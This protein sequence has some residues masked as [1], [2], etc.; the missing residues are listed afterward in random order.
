MT[1]A[2]NLSLLSTVEVGATTDQ[3]KSDIDALGI[4]RGR[5]NLII[6]GGFDVSQRGTSFTADNSYTLDR[7]KSSDG[8]GSPTPARTVTQQAFT[9]GQTDVPNA[10]YYLRHVQTTATPNANAGL[11]QKVEDVTQTSGQTFTFSFYAKASAA[12]SV[13]LNF[14]QHFGSGGSPSSSVTTTGATQT[15]STSWVKYVITKTLPSISGKTLG[16]NGDDQLTMDFTYLTS[17]TFTFEIANVQL[18][19]GSVATDFEHRSYG[20][21]LALCQRYFC[22]NFPTGTTPDHGLNINQHGVAGWTCFSNGAAARSNFIY[23]PVTMRTTPSLVLYS[24][25]SSDA[26]GVWAAYVGSWDSS[27]TNSS[28]GTNKNFNVRISAGITLVAGESYLM[29][30]NW[31]AEAEL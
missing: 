15:I 17:S 11:N 8:N 10:K 6:N 28:E 18:E 20:E 5:K 14:A 9:L 27:I 7:W 22:T 21:E 16:T 31:T 29:R 12:T 3:T 4:N 19:L 13:K 23:Y 1:K 2:R 25:S 26:D 30:G 24:A